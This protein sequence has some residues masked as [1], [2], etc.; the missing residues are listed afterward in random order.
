MPEHKWKRKRIVIDKEFQFRYLMTWV[1]LT[2]S[3]LAGVVLG[4]LSVF[5]F[6]RGDRT[7]FI[8][9]NAICA[10]LITAVSMYYIVLH[11]H[12]I[13]GPAY[14]LR[15]LLL[16]AAEGRRGF[17]V[18][19]RR[20]DYLTQVADAMNV[21]LDRLEEKEAKVNELGRQ[22]AELSHDGRDINH[23]H[24]V[25]GRVSRELLQLCPKVKEVKVDGEDGKA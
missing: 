25:A 23:V 9:V 16:E 1:L 18:K 21:L 17:R 2:T 15:K 8:W 22:I 3:L 20:K 4:S 5:I 12:R 14:R 11:S 6:F 24:D 19:L 10:A 7:Y 13:A